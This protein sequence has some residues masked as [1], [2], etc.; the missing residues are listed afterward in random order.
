MAILEKQCTKCGTVKPAKDFY[1]ERRVAD[2]LTAR[3][4]QCMKAD[5]TTSYQSRKEEVLAAHKE[6]YCAK[7]N[8]EKHLMSHYGMT[9]EEWNE[10][11]ASQN[12]RCAICGSKH[13]MH[14]N[15]HFVVDHCHDLNF[16]R[17]ILCGQCNSMLGLAKDDPDTLFDAAMY[18]W[19]RPHGEPISE[20]RSRHRCAGRGKL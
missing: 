12:Y 1:K 2:G 7:K 20:R 9:I 6:K 14:N 8:R 18:L 13:P 16:V 5:A 4:K 15:G 10:M 17:G 19:S 3:C 11:F